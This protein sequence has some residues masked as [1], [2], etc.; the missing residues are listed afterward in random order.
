MA[1]RDL[2]RAEDAHGSRRAAIG[3]RPAPTLSWAANGLDPDLV[4]RVINAY[5]TPTC[6][7][8]RE[9]G[10][11]T[12]PFS[13]GRAELDGLSADEVVAVAD[14]W[15]EMFR[16][17]PDP[18]LVCEVLNGLLGHASLTMDATTDGS[19]V[20]AAVGLAD[21]MSPSERLSARGSLALFETVSQIGV[22]RIGVCSA[23]RCVDVY[24]D[25]SPL[26][27]RQYC[28]QLCQTRERVHR[29]R[30]RTRS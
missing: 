15:F 16:S 29:Y 4:V 21:S 22:E 10:I 13:G 17:A 2:N 23:E 26:R 3:D 8:A 14:G 24:I 6:A 19:V 5:S 7:A 12:K 30:N 1:V 9:R 28:S 18:V 27:N 25:R 11:T 20:S